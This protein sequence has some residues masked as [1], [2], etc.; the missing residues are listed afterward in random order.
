MSRPPSI[1]KRIS[2]GGVIYRSGTNHAGGSPGDGIDV[3][4]VAV[5]GGKAW[6]LP[7]G[8]ID[9]GEDP[10]TAALREVREETGLSGSIVQ[11]IGRVSYWYFLKEEM[12]RIHKTVHFFLVKYIHG[13]TD[14]HDHEVDEARWV[15]IDDAFKKLTYKS[16]RDIVR[17]AKEI[18]GNM[19]KAQR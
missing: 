4:I 12:I 6:C 17:K 13:S 5:R 11:E 7:K 9:K 2:S 18:L 14:D 16:E 15:P 8:I 19:P 1:K 3:A 10:P